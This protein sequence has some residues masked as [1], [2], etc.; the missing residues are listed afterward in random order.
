VTDRELLAE[1]VS[2]GSEE[3]FSEIVERHLGRV[4][5]TCLRALGDHQ[6]AEDAAQAVFLLLVKKAG[7]ISHGTI[8]SGWLYLAARNVAMNA[9]KRRARRAK[10]ERE[11]GEMP[12][13]AKNEHSQQESWTEVRPELDAALA[14]LSG[15]QRNVVVMRYLYGKS[16]KEVAAELDCSRESVALATT[17]GLARLRDR[18]ARGGAVVP[19]AVLGTLL[20]EN[21]VAGV[22]AGLAASVTA[23]CL[24]KTAAPAA[25]V[26]L[27]QSAARAMVLVKIKLAAAVLCTVVAAGTG[28]GL[29]AN[30]LL[31]AESATAPV[32]K[33]APKNKWVKLKG[34]G[35][36]KATYYSAPVYVPV[37]KSIMQWQPGGAPKVFD[38][39][40][41]GW[42]AH[43]PATREIQAKAEAVYGNY[44]WKGSSR[45]YGK[46]MNAACWDSKRKRLVF[47]LYRM[48]VA[49]DPATK[50]WEDLKAKAIING[51][52][53]SGGPPI[54]GA[55]ACYDPVNDE[56]VT[57]PHWVPGSDLRYGRA[58]PRNVDRRDVD[59]RIGNHLGTLRFSFKDRTWRR[60]SDTFGSDEVRKARK[61][62]F[63]IMKT[64]SDASDCAYGLRRGKGPGKP[65]A[66]A[67]AL[68][69]AASD[70]KKLEVPVI[71]KSEVGRAAKELESA[72]AA[73]KKKDWAETVAAANRTLWVL[74]EEVIDGKLRVEPPPRCATAMVYD[75][76][77]KCIVMF[78]GRDGL[79][80]NDLHGPGG[81][82]GALNDT[83]VYDCRSRQWRELACPGSPPVQ[84]RARL[85]YDPATKKTF[86]VNFV[87]NWKTRKPPF[88]AGVWSLDVDAAKWTQHLALK[89]NSQLNT[90]DAKYEVGF[91]P[92]RSLLVFT[93][94]HGIRY[95]GSGKQEVYFMRLDLSAA[96]GKPAPARKPLPIRSQTIPADDPAWVAKLK[97]LP[98]NQWVLAKPPRECGRRDW[99]NVACDPVRGHVYYFG[100]G[101]STYQVNDVAI[102]AVGANKWSFAVGDHN[103][104]LPPTGWGGTAMGYRGGKWAHHQRNQYVALDGRMFVGIDNPWFYDLDRGGVWRRRKLSDR[105]KEGPA[106]N[107][108]AVHVVS[109]DGRVMALL[110]QNMVS[111]MA[112]SHT[113]KSGFSSYDIYANTLKIRN[114]TAP[115][116]SRVY[117]HRPLCF[118]PDK[119]QIFFYEHAGGKKFSS[120]KTWVFDIKTAKWTDLKP[121]NSPFSGPGS[122]R[123]AEYIEGQN[124]VW[125]VLTNRNMKKRTE[126]WVY[127]FKRNAWICMKEEG[128]NV[129]S[130]Y[131]QAA[132]VAKYGVLVAVTKRTRVM[133]VDV[134]KLKWK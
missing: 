106:P 116:P 88:D 28:G 56:I 58:E 115:F 5:A 73:A 70:M 108:S 22:P 63:A 33:N 1:Y 46:V 23:V 6:E 87:Y 38:A 60:V 12:S 52:E 92:Q 26:S 105:K 13:T 101:H 104:F 86:L 77:K 32:I 90:R 24:G 29:A 57:F 96:P 62:L 40:A 45:K 79:V 7:S 39:S 98:A 114:V 95:G 82:P 53:F 121:K 54:F 130:P 122:V 64:V 31:A 20:L 81:G 8:L 118:M 27:A 93:Q 80:R 111:R 91:D 125:C 55:G 134:D 78:G 120:Q 67:A 50:K 30:R 117:E 103:D 133:R 89:W 68:S 74:N 83:W 123:L 126:Y 25:A 132:Y 76:E 21:G 102:Y 113:G 61:Q 127:S 124:A 36:E 51:K 15:H 71:V 129:G 41:P 17:R 69:K 84:H 10:H 37:L 65:D 66:V 128:M 4:L 75:P 131:G 94:F 59:G 9:L 109:P 11:A 112:K 107:E 100:G 3:A 2:K 48:T 14:A 42:K 49:Y 43:G 119:N 72:T 34:S 35:G 110:G 97:T 18:L 19:V 47:A 44:K 85:F 99:G 16:Q